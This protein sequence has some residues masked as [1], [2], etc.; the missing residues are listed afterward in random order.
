MFN[1]IWIRRLLISTSL[2]LLEV[3]FVLL[4]L[5]G[6]TAWNWGLVFIPIWVL[7][8]LL[9]A[10]IQYKLFIGI[11][12]RPQPSTQDESSKTGSYY[13]QGSLQYLIFLILSWITI[14][15]FFIFLTIHLQGNGW[16]WSVI[17]CPLWAL[18]LLC[19]VY[20]IIY[21]S[22]YG[23]QIGLILLIT[24]ILV[25][26][27]SAFIGAQLDTLP[28]NRFNWAIVFIPIWLLFGVWFGALIYFIVK[29]FE[30]VFPVIAR[31]MT[32]KKQ[33]TLQ[34]KPI[35]T[36][37]TTKSKKPPLQQEDI[38][39]FSLLWAGILTFAIVLTVRLEHPSSVSY[40]G[41]FMP[42]M[43]MFGLLFVVAYV[44]YYRRDMYEKQQRLYE[45]QNSSVPRQH[46]NLASKEPQGI[47]N[48]DEDEPN[49]LQDDIID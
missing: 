17:I 30:Y 27:V 32:E 1:L 39:I 37:P 28:E 9:L 12:R 21:W 5:N 43:A 45:L 46:V 36:N 35:I 47:I 10:F 42:L 33:S 14:S 44:I 11:R 34:R 4:R 7:L 23:K 18:L 48:I 20:S 31:I 16:P 40:L 8:F 41:L 6:N 19:L 3:I 49:Q 24:W 15:L 26:I 2:L 25:I 29:Y 22:S 38:I 13:E